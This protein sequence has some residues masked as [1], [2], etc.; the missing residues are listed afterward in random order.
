M[1]LSDLELSAHDLAAVERQN[2][3]HAGTMERCWCHVCDQHYERPHEDFRDTL[4]RVRAIQHFN[5]C[6]RPI[7]DESDLFGTGCAE[8]GLEKDLENY[9]VFEIC[10]IN[11]DKNDFRQSNL[12]RLCRN[13]K[14]VIENGEWIKHHVYN[15]HGGDW[16]EPHR[17]CT[18]R[19]KQ[20]P[21]PEALAER[22]ARIAA[23]REKHGD[24]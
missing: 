19:E 7:D 4:L 15:S 5:G 12:V 17:F 22:S 3:S 2:A 13:C 21:T 9:V 11:G 16:E 24:R 20:R 1:I 8:C 10:H 6:D 14:A 18:W 23:W